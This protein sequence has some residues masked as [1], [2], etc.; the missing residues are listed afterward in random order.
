MDKDIRKSVENLE[1]GYELAQEEGMHGGRMAQTLEVNEELEDR[2]DLVRKL[3]ARI[4]VMRGI[5]LGALAVLVIVL[6]YACA[7]MLQKEEPAEEKTEPEIVQTAVSESLFYRMEVP[8][9]DVS[10]IR[11]ATLE[12]LVSGLDGYDFLDYLGVRYFAGSE[13]PQGVQ[14]Y[15]MSSLEEL[16]SSTGREYTESDPPAGK[17]AQELRG[18]RMQRP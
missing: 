6:L 12:E 18:S 4:K 8:D 13:A 14:V 5:A 16:V 17:D 11:S 3:K 10:Q 7:S 2:L 15:S 9:V 1:R